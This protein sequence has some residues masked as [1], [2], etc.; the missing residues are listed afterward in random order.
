MSLYLARGERVIVGADLAR[1]PL[2]LAAAAARR[3]GLERVQLVETD[4]F[5]PGLR[6]GAFDVVYSSGV[7]HH[8]P[9]PRE[10]FARLARLAKPGGMIVVGLYNAFARVPLR[11]RRLI[12]RVSGYRV[13]P[14]DSVLRDREHEP[15]RRAAWVRDQYRHLE[16]HRHTLAEVQ[17]WFAENAVE[18]I[19]TY[20][21][22][23]LDND[24][25]ELFERATDNWR[26]EGWLAQLGWIWALG[27]E[28]GM[29]V[30]IGRRS[31]D[32]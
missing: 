20:P 14:F 13:I 15:A 10:A 27:H 2:Q 9:N 8:T 6:A 21:S 23:V 11:L 17:R 28:G 1:A 12:A 32:R 31:K 25:G 30:T 22:S 4:L 29:F 16:E 3:F 5:A 7:L 18:Y 26:V 24:A 19:R